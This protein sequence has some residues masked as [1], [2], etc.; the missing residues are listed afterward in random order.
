MAQLSEFYEGRCIGFLQAGKSIRWAA[1]RLSVSTATVQHLVESIWARE[2]YSPQR[3]KW[4]P[5]HNIKN[6][7]SLST[8]AYQTQSFYT[9]FAFITILEEWKHSNCSEE[10]FGNG[11]SC[12]APTALDPFVSSA[13]VAHERMG[14]C[15]L[16]LVAR[17]V[18]SHL[19]DG[20]KQVLLGLCGWSCESSTNEE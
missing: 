2:Q 10:S 17:Y 14:N 16:H 7:R 8:S 6:K 5:A 1:S 12:F 11:T 18:V 9:S 15:A 4:T 20:R 19:M 13:P 3:R